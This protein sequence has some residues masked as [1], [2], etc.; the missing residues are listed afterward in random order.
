MNVDQHLSELKSIL[1]KYDAVSTARKTL[2]IHELNTCSF[3]KSKEFKIY[4]Q[5]LHGLLAY[6]SGQEMLNLT[7]NSLKNLIQQLRRNK[8]LQ[9]KFIGTGLAYSDIE[10]NFS[11]QMV[12]YL[13]SQFPGQISIH[14]VSSTTETQKNVLK[15]ILPYVE[16]SRI[17][18]GDFDFKKRLS[19]FSTQ[20]N[21]TDLEWLI[22]Q[23]DNTINDVNTR[24]F[25]FNQLGIFIQWQIK[26]E[27]TSVSFLNGINLP[28]YFH[29]QPNS[30]VVLSDILS[31]KLPKPVKLSA[32]QRKKIID[33]AR[34]SLCYLYRE[35][36]PFTNANPDD[37]TL[38]HLDHGISIA[39]FGSISAKRYSLESYIGYLVFKNNIPASYGGG[40]I[41]GQRSQFGINILESFR[42]GESAL[43]ICELLRVYHQYFG[44]N[45]FVVKPYQF[46]LHNSEAIKTGAF[47]FYYKL[48]FWPVDQELRK[49]A[50]SENEKKKTIPNYKSEAATLR[51]FTKSNI[52]L[53][54]NER[55]YPDYDSERL[56]QMIT[57]FINTEYNGNRQAALNACFKQLCKNLNVKPSFFKSQDVD[58]AK[59]CAVLFSIKASS[60][61]W[62]LKN[63]SQIIKFITLKTAAT[64]LEWIKH[65][66]GFKAFWEY[67]K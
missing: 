67:I 30:Q 21:Q 19:F 10:C 20:V 36:E 66:H 52:E 45:R 37:I 38:F 32:S 35:T 1:F 8:T 27:S 31:H 6:P 28:I 56:S 58:Y 16:Y 65:L 41:F 26:D 18:L 15:L 23:M 12:S 50:S 53:V 39:L 14:S 4:H 9:G 40:W 48:G 47:W 62:Q 7:M 55:A 17:H 33:A 25:V 13:I 61:D 44:V 2:L 22:S 51:K 63:K 57:S 43:I 54:L 34:L 42:G 60:D 64:E 24:A 49:L 11:Y 46:G 3:N 59:Q 29:K 5:L